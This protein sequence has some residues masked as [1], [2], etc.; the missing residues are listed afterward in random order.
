VCER[1][2][3]GRWEELWRM[4]G[5]NAASRAPSLQRLAL[6]KCLNRWY[7]LGLCRECFNARTNQKKK[8]RM[9][10]HVP[11]HGGVLVAQHQPN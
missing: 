1:A 9:L 5:N 7:P 10:G 8:P 2:E 4:C 3:V 6:W 11:P